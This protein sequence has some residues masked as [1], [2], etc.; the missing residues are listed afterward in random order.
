MRLVARL[1]AA[2]S[3]WHGR[4]RLPLAEV[5]VVGVAPAAEVQAVVVV[6]LLPVVV[7]AAAGRL[8]LRASLSSKNGGLCDW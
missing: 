4:L 8:L 5:L 3:W 7:A 1:V 6:L 2:H